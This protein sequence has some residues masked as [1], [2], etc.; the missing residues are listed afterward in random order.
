MNN[1]TIYRTE[2]GKNNSVNEL[3]ASGQMKNEEDLFDIFFDWLEEKEFAHTIAPDDE[4][5]GYFT[6]L[7][8]GNDVYYIVSE[9]NQHE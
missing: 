9:G 7:D 4:T 6:M 1:W 5:G 2:C 3:M 8:K